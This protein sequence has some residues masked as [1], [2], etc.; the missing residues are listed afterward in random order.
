MRS[1]FQR[2]TASPRRAGL[3]A[4]AA[5]LGGAL[6]TVL[7]TG[8]ACRGKP[9]VGFEIGLPQ[10]LVDTTAWFE[11]AAYRDAS[12]S[13]VAPMLANG[14]P[15]GATVRIAFR[16]DDTTTP[17]VGDLPRG[18]YAFA[19]VAKDEECAIL[20]SG[21][22]DA[23]VPDTD[24]VVVPMSE[25]D[26]PTGG[27]GQGAACQAGRCVPANDNAD[28][29]VGAGCSLELLGSGPL[30][31]GG[32]AGT[33]VSAP[34]IEA[35]PSG[36]VVV[37][38]EVD[39]NGT[40][41]KITILPIDPAGGALP[42]ARP[43]LGNRCGTLTENDGVGLA[44]NGKDG[45]LMVAR[46]SCGESQGGLEVLAFDSKPEI[47]TEGASRLLPLTAASVS[48]SA[49]HVA[50]NKPS[51]SVLAFVEDG[52]ANVAGVTADGVQPPPGTFGAASANTGAWV[53][54]SDKVLALLA[55]GPPG[56]APPP[57]D[58]D[59]GADGGAEGGAP[60]APSGG[61][62]G[63]G[64]GPALRLLML[65]IDTP[66]DQIVAP[67]TP[68]API[69]FSG[70]WGAVAARGT[71]VIVM[72]DG[73][74]PGR[75]VTYRTFDLNG[76]EAVETNGFSLDGTGKAETGDVVIHGDRV[77]F[78]SLKP[79]TIALHAFD[80]ASTTP[81]PLH[82]IFFAK[83]PR[84]AG[85]DLVRDGRVALAVTD[86]RVAVVWTTAKTLQENDATGGYAVFACTP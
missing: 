41:A 43:S 62:A 13:A 50:A 23:K 56:A 8:A 20:A 69:Q 42:P 18:K 10:D 16:R 73:S 33:L 38:R 63:E 30:A 34:A 44:M 64:D 28:P 29:S 1:R 71:R 52:V 83:E 45:V 86:A 22:T 54:A 24:K 60:P 19:A 72:S 21:C 15:D 40:T 59:A 32:G 3:S 25:T 49:G 68:R 55:A 5:G 79:G 11:I 39:P 76:A 85:V 67:A 65:P 31:T 37:Y 48:L 46:P 26:E 4:R 47:T 6:L 77:F 74:G 17:T 81:R 61:G 84:I 51:A 2:R 78:A 70:E 66:L 57:P 9:K 35:T 82:Q 58:L 80:G 75:S 12:C 7:A 53:A 14:V 27:C 36:F